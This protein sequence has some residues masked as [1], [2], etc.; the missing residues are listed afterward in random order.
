MTSTTSAPGSP[1]EAVEVRTENLFQRTEVLAGMFHNRMQE[2]TRPPLLTYN[3]CPIKL[4]PVC[5]SIFDISSVIPAFSSKT[6]IC[7]H[8]AEH[9]YDDRYLKGL[10]PHFGIHAFYISCQVSDDK[11]DIFSV[12]MANVKLLPAAG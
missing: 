12:C 2:N 6:V 9:R 7:F 8:E 10:V 11:I 4:T 3:I 1:Q 5:V